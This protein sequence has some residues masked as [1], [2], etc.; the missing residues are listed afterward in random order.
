MAKDEEGSK[1]FPE[2]S[3]KNYGLV[4]RNSHR[5]MISFG[6]TKTKVKFTLS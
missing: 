3:L 5:N 6:I 1:E 4:F 2:E